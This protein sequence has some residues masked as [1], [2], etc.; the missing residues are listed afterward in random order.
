MP[1][2]A[3]PRHGVLL[4]PAGLAQ[5]NPQNY[6]NTQYY[7]KWCEQTFGDAYVS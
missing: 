6:S 4:G 1:P 7:G 3:H 5:V 2:A